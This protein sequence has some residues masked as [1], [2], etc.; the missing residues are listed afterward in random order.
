MG[1][2]FGHTEELIQ[3]GY[4]STLKTKLP[5]PCYANHKQFYLHDAS[6]MLLQ[7]ERSSWEAHG[8]FRCHETLK[9]P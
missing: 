5:Q 6:L 2:I 1:A 4:A 9:F 8:A 3:R 7:A